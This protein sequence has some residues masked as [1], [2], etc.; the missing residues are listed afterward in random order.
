MKKILIFGT[1]VVL[2]LA[3]IL[4]GCGSGGGGTATTQHEFIADDNTVALWHFNEISGSTV[5]DSSKTGSYLLTLASNNGN[6]LPSFIN[7]GRSGFGNCL[8]LNSANQQYAHTSSS[9]NAFSA[10]KISVEFWVKFDTLVQEP[11]LFGG[12]DNDIRIYIKDTGKLHCMIW[13][14]TAW[15][16]YYSTNTVSTGAWHYIAFTYDGTNNKAA[17]YID[18]SPDSTLTT[19]TTCS[20][21][22]LNPC[23]VGGK[24]GST[25][26]YTGLQDEVRVSSCVRTATEISNYYTQ[27][28]KP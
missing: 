13:D 28:I 12:N 25:F 4:S 21:T 8:S 17:F 23:Y 1:L 9:M 15:I 19:T 3:A 5:A 11:P 16:D 7:S 14:G 18:G 10:H 6:S 22:P 20:F 24:P 2:I 26:W 27:A